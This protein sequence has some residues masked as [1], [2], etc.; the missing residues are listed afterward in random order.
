MRCSC[1]VYVYTLGTMV[2]FAQCHFQAGGIGAHQHCNGYNCAQTAL[3]LASSALV[4]TSTTEAIPI[5]L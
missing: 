5:L 2:D 1:G 3:I 4:S